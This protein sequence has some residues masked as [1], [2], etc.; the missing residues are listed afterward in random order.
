MANENPFA[1]LLTSNTK[2]STPA[3]PAASSPSSSNP[4]SG[5]I[6][7]AEVKA[8]IKVFPVANS[9]P[10]GQK[11]K[12]PVS[13]YGVGNIDLNSRPVVTNADGSI[14]TVRS[15]SITDDNGKVILIP[16]VIKDSSGTGKVVSNDEA[17]KHY[18]D[19]GEYLGKFNSEDEADKYA[20]QLHED[21]AKQYTSPSSDSV[22]VLSMPKEGQKVISDNNVNPEDEGIIRQIVQTVL[23]NSYGGKALSKLS[24]NLGI[25]TQ[26]DPDS[27]ADTIKKQYNMQTDYQV[28]KG[29]IGHVNKTITDTAT[30]ALSD[31]P[32][33]SEDYYN[34]TTVG[35]VIKEGSIAK[36]GFI[37]G[38]TGGLVN[39]TAVATPKTT[40]DK[41]SYIAGSAVGAMISIAAFNKMAGAAFAK[42][43]AMV[44]LASKY[45]TVAKFAVPALEN[46]VGFTAYGQ[47]DPKDDNRLKRAAS[48]ILL[49]IPY[50]IAG[51]VIPKN[52]KIGKTNIPG[53]AVSL[54][55]LF[56][57]GYGMAKMDGASDGD[58]MIQGATL[59]ALDG[60][61]RV[62]GR[63][64]STKSSFDT[65]VMEQTLK[66]T[67]IDRLNKY[68]GTKLNSKSTKAEIKAAY[69]K[70]SQITH[71]DKLTGNSQDFQ[72]VNNAY[73]IL[74]GKTSNLFEANG[75]ASK[76]A[77]NNPFKG[78]LTEKAGQSAEIAPKTAK[79]EEAPIQTPAVMA[80]NRPVR[81]T[82][83]PSEYIKQI[84]GGVAPKPAIK[85]EQSPVKEGTSA[86]MKE[87]PEENSAVAEK[88][89]EDNYAE[90]YGNLSNRLAD[91]QNQ[92]KVAKTKDRSFL[93]DQAKNVNSELYK[94]ENDFIV[95][96]NKNAV[97]ES[98]LIDE[99]KKY[100]SAEE[101]GQSL[102]TEQPSEIT[103]R[104]IFNTHT[105]TPQP[106][107]DYGKYL[108][109]ETNSINAENI[110]GEIGSGGVGYPQTIY[111]SNTPELALGQGGKKGFTF[112]FDSGE[113]GGFEKKIQK[114]SSGYLLS[115]GKTDELI[116]K[117][118]NRKSIIG[119]K[120]PA[121]FE[122]KEYK[123][124]L[125]G[126]QNI[127]KGQLT[128]MGLS[129]EPVILNDGS[130]LYLK[131]QFTDIWNKTQS[132]SNQ[133]TVNAEPI[134]EIPEKIVREKPVVQQ[135]IELINEGKD[136]E[137]QASILMQ[138]EGS[139]AGER[140]H[141]EDPDGTQH[142]IGVPSSFPK[143]I[144]EELRSQKLVDAV[145]EHIN[146]ETIPT[147]ANEVRL[148]N[149]VAEQMGL[150]KGVNEI[151]AENDI[152]PAE[153]FKDAKE[154]DKVYGISGQEEGGNKEEAPVKQPV[155]E[156]NRG[157]EKEKEA[158]SNPS[159]S[160]GQANI[161]MFND[162]TPVIAGG[163]NNIKPIQ[164]PELVNLVKELT[165]GIPTMNKRLRTKLGVFFGR[166]QGEIQLNPSIFN[167]PIQVSKVLAHE[168]G[169]LIDWIPRT[170]L[171]RTSLSQKLYILK[172]NIRTEFGFDE[173]KNKDIKKELW[174][175]STYWR[176]L[177]DN[178]TEGFMKYRKSSNELYADAISALFNSPR[179]V[180][181][182]APNFY[183][184]FF[185]SLN[186]KPEVNENY[187]EIQDLLR[188]AKD[189]LFEARQ[190][191]I[192]KGFSRAEDIQKSFV[193][194]KKLADSNLMVNLRQQLDDKYYPIL[195]KLEADEA[196]GLIVDDNSNPRYLLQENDYINNENYLFVDKM[197]K[198]ISKPIKE[199]G[200]TD[201]DIGIYLLL[202]RISNDRK[203]IANPY[204]LDLNTSAD[205]L[206]YLKKRV[207]EDNFKLLEQKISQF[208]DEVFKSVEKAVEVGSYNKKIF[209]ETIKPN[210]DTYASFGV[211]D[212]LQD[213]VP[214]TVKKQIGTFK[215][216]ANP[217]YQ[218][219]LKT[220]T[221]NKLNSVQEAKNS[222]RDYLLKNHADEI[223]KTKE[224]RGGGKI[225][226]FKPEKDRG[227]LIMLEDGKL[228]SY[229]VDPYIAKSFEYEDPDNLNVAVKLIDRFNN[230]FKS[231]VTTYNLGFAAAF[232]PIRDF[233]R[234]Y[235]NIP[236]ATV[237]NL[238]EAYV[239]SL[240][241]ATRYAKGQ[242]DDITKQMVA[243]K[244]ISAPMYD[245]NY[246][247]RDDGMGTILE[248]YGIITRDTPEKEIP[249]AMTKARKFLLTPL[250]KTLEGIRFIANTF[251]NVSKIAGT[252]VRMKAGE[253]GKELAYNVRNYT[254][255][256]NW[257]VKGTKTSTTNAIFIF[258]NIMKE[259]IKSD[260][261]IA[262]NP[263]T[264]SG[265]WWKSIKVD[266]L[267]KFLM[268]AASAG[269]FGAYLKDQFDKMTEYD[270]TNYLCIPLGERNGKA[271]YLRIPHDE[272]N[273]VM[274]AIMWKVLNFAKNR[275]LNG[276]E[277]VF[278]LAAGQLPGV[279]PL[280]TVLEAWTQYLSGKNPY[281]SF[282]GR[283]LIDDTTFQAGGMDSLKK[284]VEWTANEFG[285]SQFTTYDSTKNDTL[286]LSV[287]ILPLVNRVLKITDYGIQEQYSS[288]E[289]GLQK[290]RAQQLV[291]E[292]K[293]ITQYTAKY[294]EEYYKGNIEGENLGKNIAIDLFGHTPQ[295]A[296]ELSRYKSVVKRLK[297]SL[298]VGHYDARFDN[299]AYAGTNKIKVAL[300][301]QYQKDMKPEDYNSLL[302]SLGEEHIISKEV[303]DQVQ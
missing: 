119:L 42:N 159:F 76:N 48:D 269:L 230:S 165:G 122:L 195:K 186:Q 204:G 86:I 51:S 217:Y 39:P 190:N 157:I 121:N 73:R 25:K 206:D 38:L 271:V 214:A 18:Y 163:F 210:K 284:M 221:L 250:T 44:T 198:E 162:K 130:K 287:Q 219:I 28:A 274:S 106:L 242:L 302:E 10:F 141:W 34:N 59:M 303:Y 3:S 126:S 224:I 169:H 88:D 234:N 158:V 226:V 23:P 286:E 131:S 188:G 178:P 175:L 127:V 202:K 164:T 56:T 27:L 297:R 211:V 248:K 298:A 262:T 108:Y 191:R 184:A 111:L 232:N 105:V 102:L 187:W 145:L 84:R 208:H 194:K 6:S 146:K 92:I 2:K 152:D 189:E 215:D 249:A 63:I 69:Y 270:K 218:T 114:P 133:E 255:T 129:P 16:T 32:V 87:I 100:S 80:E 213:Y 267:P 116:G 266:F 193:E 66:N 199:A 115:Q 20:Q 94:M 288:L 68:A 17:V 33:H 282:H 15:I 21:Q 79:E 14:S 209:E 273:R 132:S 35:Q 41:V 95:K 275:N 174:D 71:T 170:G 183:T 185:D 292:K 276:M 229:D 11:V 253:T 103:K 192:T 301:K 65:Q 140:I 54:P 277:D 261:Q 272:T 263:K 22:P 7:K 167:D 203:D 5:I 156:E 237:F 98:S 55:T 179:I 176:P 148:Y 161:G 285:L 90:E 120:V 30:E 160:G 142:T 149:T 113:V 139:K 240:P 268:F 243:D 222:I 278:S 45:P 235:K 24:S 260:F 9:N 46:A 300:L 150:I 180:E 166:G 125:D 4:F 245:Y 123:R 155:S 225:S 74:T 70:A 197:D 207:G 99:A 117:D 8:P 228:K 110:L 244:I 281:D 280:I 246:D 67:A 81:G 96:Y 216:V 49:S 172:N 31:K 93:I 118:F 107:K 296:D 177:G 283:T 259:G 29:T 143:W 252:K 294:K 293:L 12:E 134:K 171:K 182:K 137:T 128:R 265:Y 168:I 264:R 82:E 43:V 13:N 247:P 136:A 231:L 138:L 254:G 154:N 40:I 181:T 299:I 77:E 295:N 83:M 1:G 233:K 251:E 212:Y 124:N 57:L 58:A 290:E 101:F 19:T 97:Q 200:M 220:C 61:S 60:F 50:S 112:I 36:S 201:D 85:T 72:I 151:A 241:S 91:L 279:T 223:K 104:T 196:N 153:L 258:S 135:K 64:G 257:K 89:W 239:K 291:Q 78:L 52:L 26:Y 75:T 256:P 62:S 37:S 238:I 173:V 144:P 53:E 109:H 147:K 289:T 47:L 236:N 205:Q 227:Q